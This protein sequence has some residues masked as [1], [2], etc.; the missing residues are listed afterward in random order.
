MAQFAI[1]RTRKLKSGAA[2]RGLERHN[3]RLRRSLVLTRTAPG[4]IRLSLAK[5]SS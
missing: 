1:M 4:I 3:E 2:M 5:T